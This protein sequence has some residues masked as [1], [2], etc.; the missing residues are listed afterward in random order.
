MRF[1]LGERVEISGTVR[2]VRTPNRT[3]FMPD[4]G[5]PNRAGK[6]VREGIITGFRTVVPGRVERW[7]DEYPYFTPDKNAA[8][9][10]WLVT[11]NLRSKAVMCFDD[12]LL[13][14]DENPNPWPPPRVEP[15]RVRVPV[16]VE[17][18]SEP[19]LTANEASF[20]TRIPTRTLAY[21]ADMGALR[22]E[23]KTPTGHRRYFEADILD[24]VNDGAAR[25]EV[26]KT[27]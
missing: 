1:R 5:V 24:I 6:E 12:Q 7:Y 14:L 27:D 4:G 20:L 10:V 25:F 15:K 9:P 11:Y 23:R 17:A 16:E 18:D 21:W 22:C 26:D 3:D 19:M 8:L 2:K 13:S